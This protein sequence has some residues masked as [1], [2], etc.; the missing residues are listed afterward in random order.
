MADFP[1]TQ[2]IAAII[3][4]NA[5]AAA[6][7][8]RISA[9]TAG[10]CVAAAPPRAPPPA[11]AVPAAGPRDIATIGAGV[12]RALLNALLTA[13]GVP[14]NSLGTLTLTPCEKRLSQQT[15]QLTRASVDGYYS[16]VHTGSGQ[17]WHAA[18]YGYGPRTFLSISGGVPWGAAL[19]L[20]PCD[21]SPAQQ[22]GLAKSEVVGSSPGGYVLTVRQ[23]QLCVSVAGVGGAGGG[24][25]GVAPTLR[26][27]A[28]RATSPQQ[29]FSVIIQ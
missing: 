18:Q 22:F 4:Q 17:C 15:F 5:P 11:A 1:G 16:I 13:I 29:L 25:S 26:Q 23:T 14:V 19:V 3:Q 12:W 6:A 8:V 21:G 9:D 27:A 2:L 7:G 10:L 24:E 28:C 20:A